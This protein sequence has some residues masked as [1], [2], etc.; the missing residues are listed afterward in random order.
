M[1]ITAGQQQPQ[2]E[3]TIKVTPGKYISTG[4]MS[5][6][7]S[8]SV[9]ICGPHGLAA[10]KNPS[11]ALLRLLA[12][13]QCFGKCCTDRQLEQPSSSSSSGGTADLNGAVS[14]S[15][16]HAAA[17]CSCSC[18]RCNVQLGFKFA[19]PFAQ[20]EKAD[21]RNYG[22]IDAYVSTLERCYA[23]EWDIIYACS[24]CSHVLSGYAL[25][26]LHGG[27]HV[28]PCMLMELSQLGDVTVLK[29]PPSLSAPRVGSMSYEQAL[30]IVRQ[31]TIGLAALHDN[32]TIYCDLKPTNMLLFGDLDEPHIKLIDLT[33]S[34][35]LKDEDADAD[36]FTVTEGW[37]APEAWGAN[38]QTSS[39]IDVWILGVLLLWLRRGVSGVTCSTAQ[40]TGTA[41]C[42]QISS[43]ERSEQKNLE[44]CLC[45]ERTKRWS[46]AQLLDH[47]YLNWQRSATEFQTLSGG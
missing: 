45:L 1:V 46:A 36:G 15:G 25:G 23:K 27:S 35:C 47:P 30:H 31:V 9:P 22:S 26:E 32:S 24:T 40:L 33:T 18:N 42:A 28:R 10:L 3:V 20:I 7:Y 19:R 5:A 43:L 34:V 44:C 29:K 16:A 6:V 39:T 13:Q 2:P 8:A 12:Q 38:A 4:A 21:K 14:G 11:P 17:G 37:V 41:P